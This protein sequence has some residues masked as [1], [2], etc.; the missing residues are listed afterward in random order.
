MDT[1]RGRLSSATVVGELGQG[2]EGEVAGRRGWVAGKRGGV[3]G[4]SGGGWGGGDMGH[5]APRVGTAARCTP[6][7]SLHYFLDYQMN[8]PVS[9]GEIVTGLSSGYLFIPAVV[10][11]DVNAINILV[12]VTVSGR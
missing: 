8:F 1:A 9:V 6:K 12:K 3:A 7:Y 4:R 5:G 10:V 11:D 2:K